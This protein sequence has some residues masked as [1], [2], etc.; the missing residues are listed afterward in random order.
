MYL[1]DSK[2]DFK[3][4]TALIRIDS[5]V[6][7]VKKDGKWIVDEDFRLRS[8]L[9]TINLLKKKGVKRIVFLG[10]LG[11]PKG[12]K[13]KELSLEPIANWFGKALSSCR[14]VSLKECFSVDSLFLSSEKGKL[15]VTQ[16][17]ENKFC[18]SDNLRFDSGEKTNDKKFAEKLAS[19]G[20]VYINDAFGVSH[21]EHASIVGIPKLLPSFLGVRFE[22]EIK[23]LSWLKK[24]A[25]RP[26]VFVLGGSKPGKLSYIDFLSEWADWLLV[27]GKLPSYS[28]DGKRKGLKV[29]RLKKN[30]KDINKETVKEFKEIIKKGKTVAW[31][32]P[33]GV[34]EEEENRHGTWEIAKAVGNAI[35]FKAAGGGDTHRI[36]S[37]AKLWNKFDFVSVGGG[38]MLQFLKNETLPG[39]EAVK[40]QSSK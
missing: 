32:G 26:L 35:A 5:D 16:N 33:M 9:P 12:K 34:Y 1:S 28:F 7:L 22:G 13:T 15:C 39:I 3:D 18:L 27:G 17:G 20:D 31:A 25:P 2:F 36:L 8:V 29:G 4:K 19:F 40:E 11:R 38:A 6:D 23:A 24:N 10:H 21:R 30:G 14:F 37:W